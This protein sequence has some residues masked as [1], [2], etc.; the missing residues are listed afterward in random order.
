MAVRKYLNQLVPLFFWLFNESVCGSLSEELHQAAL[1]D[2]PKAS[3]QVEEGRQEDQ[4]DWN[5]LVVRV[6]NGTLNVVLELKMKYSDLATCFLPASY[7]ERKNRFITLLVLADNLHFWKGKS[8]YLLSSR[9]GS[10]V[11]FGYLEVG[12]HPA[13]RLQYIV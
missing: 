7:V 10:L 8:F 12:V 6:V 13:V 11:F 1:H 5:P 3:R 9:T 2:Q 4:E